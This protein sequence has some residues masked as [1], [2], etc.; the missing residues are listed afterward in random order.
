MFAALLFYTTDYGFDEG[1]DAYEDDYDSEPDAY[2]L[3]MQQYEQQ[4]Q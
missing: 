4:K 1:C 2:T 3:L